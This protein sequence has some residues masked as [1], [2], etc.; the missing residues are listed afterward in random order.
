MKSTLQTL[1]K[2]VH[3]AVFDKSPVPQTVFRLQHVDGASWTVADRV[4]TARA[5][6]LERTYALGSITI[7]QLAD[8]L[9]ADGFQVLDLS[10]DF[11]AL[12]G[13]VLVEGEGGQSVSNGDR[14]QGFTSL[15]WV[16][17]TGY[18]AET[19]TAREQVR[20]ALRQ[21]VITQAE[22]E[23]LDVWG[24]LYG[25]QRWP[26]EHDANYATRI[27]REAFRM[28]NNARAIERAVFEATGFDVR[29][30]EPWREIF[31]LDHS[32]LSGGDKLYDGGTVGYH[33]IR[34]EALDDT[35]DWTRVLPIIDRNKPAGVIV[36]E[37]LVRPTRR[38]WIELENRGQTWSRRRSWVTARS[39]W[40]GFN[41][42]ID[43][44]RSTW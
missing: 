16:L 29:I 37:Y 17:M 43:T 27:P 3:G 36:S 30:N 15:L 38:Y 4:M 35:V 21:M 25:V 39:T 42:V 9:V 32:A 34:P 41:G 12:L 44:W 14:L 10:T 13:V 23:W 11:T 8:A 5:G 28:R 22:N 26:G 1:L 31:R 20:Q 40:V 18:A 19:M 7:A 6:S 24:L 33:L 2:Y